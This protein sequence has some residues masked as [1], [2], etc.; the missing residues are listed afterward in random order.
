MANKAADLVCRNGL[1]VTPARSISPGN[2]F[3]LVQSIPNA[4]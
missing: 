3:F 1:I 4:I 2:I